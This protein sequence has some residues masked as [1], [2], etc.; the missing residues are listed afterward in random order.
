MD[1]LT[2]LILIL[3]GLYGLFCI[4]LTLVGLPGTWLIAGGALGIVIIYSVSSDATLWSW[5]T[6]GIVFGLAIVGEIL[7]T[8]A[9]GIGSKAGGGTKRGMI[10]AIVGSI[11][12]ALACTLLLPIP[13]IGTLIGAVAGAFFGA[14]LGELS[15]K[16]VAKKSDLA[17]SATGAALGRVMGIVAKTGIAAACWCVLM[18]EPLIR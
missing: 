9:A 11:F 12:G 5:V 2:I 10:G 1:W 8:T 7:E 6:I 14:L 3:F 4:L 16:E 13:L 15:H 17:K 18:L